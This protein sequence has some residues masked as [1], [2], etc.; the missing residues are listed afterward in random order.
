MQFPWLEELTKL[1]HIS[2]DTRD[3]IYAECEAV[4]GLG[5]GTSA[6][7]MEKTA[8]ELTIPKMLAGFA[9]AAVVSNLVGNKMN[10][11]KLNA[12]LKGEVASLLRNKARVLANPDFAAH[13]EKAEARFNEI[14]EIAP[15]VA[16]NHAVVSK[17]VKDKL[18]NGLTSE[19]VT[20]LALIQASYTP[21]YSVQKRLT[22][23]AAGAELGEAAADMVLICAEA[24]IVKK[25]AGGLSFGS[26]LGKVLSHSLMLTAGPVLLGLGRGVIDSLSD[27]RNKVEREKR[28]RASY[29][30]AIAHPD[31]DTLRNDPDKAMQ[32]FQTLTHFSPHVAMQ[33]V[34]ARS[35]M[36]KLVDYKG[37]VHSGDIKDLVTIEKDM[38][39]TGP[40]T[41]LKSMREGADAAGF[42]DAFK[43][44]LK[45][46][47][48][49]YSR[50]LE[51]EFETHLGMRGG[52]AKP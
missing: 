43:S 47:N 37:D 9:T 5:I 13:L 42:K 52:P 32:A 4:V 41:F 46:I 22:K 24:G 45:P 2:P 26:G 44:G 29:E 19:D 14:A 11:M 18:H 10:S 38:R 12:E 51:R 6:L 39:G 34:A 15:T 35:F 17:L 8:L 20:N 48:D 3:S 36:K 23:E 27:S 1:G 50:Q 49:P 31:A 25:A 21:N 30:E 28:L 40:S 16:Q 7:P 33:P